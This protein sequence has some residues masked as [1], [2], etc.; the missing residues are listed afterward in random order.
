TST[1]NQVINVA[2]V[3]DAPIDGNETNI[4][5]QNATLTV[6]VG[7]NS[8]L[9]NTTDVDGST[10][11]VTSFLVAGNAT[12]F[13]VTAGTPGVANIAGVGVLTINSD[14][15][16]SFAPVANYAGAIPV[17]TYT[18]SDNAAVNPLTDSSTL[19]LTIGANNPPVDGDETNSITEDLTLTVAN[20][21]VGDLLNNATDPDNNP[22]SITSFLVAGNATPFAVT[23]GTPGVANIA[24]VGVLTINSD[25]SYS[26]APVANYAGAIPVIT[27]TVADG[28][29][30]SNT[31]TLT[32]T[33]TAV[34]DAPINTVPVA[35]TNNEDTSKAITGLSI[36]DVDAGSSSMTVTLA[37]TY[38]TLTVTGGTAAIAG[39]GTSSVTLTGT[40]A[41][42]NTTLA[43]NVIYVPTLNFNGAATLT[44]TS[45]DNGNTGSGGTLTD[46]DTVTINVSP[47]ND[48]PVNAM[49]A[50]YTTNEDTTLKLSGLSVTDVDAGTGSITVTLS[51]PSSNGTIAAT[52][53]G[54]VTV[55]GSGTTSIT[56]TGTLAN[57]NAYLASAT[58]QPT[59]TPAKDVSGTVQLTM[60]TSD[61]G[62][63]GTGNVL[64]DT[65]TVNITITPIA[66]PISDPN[67]VSVVVGAAISNTIDLSSG[68]SGVDGV[69]SFTFGNGVIMSSGSGANFN[70]SNG[71]DLGVKGGPSG[72][73]NRIDGSES[74]IFSFPSGM[75][76]MS[77]QLKNTASDTLKLTAGLEVPDLNSSG[78]ITG[79]VTCP[80][81]QGTPS[82]SNMQ[83]SLVLQYT[84]G[85][86][87]SPF[88]ATV[89]SGGAWSLSY[90]TGGKTI[91]SANV[92][93][94]V[95]GDLFNNG[96]T[97][98]T[99]FNISTDMKSFTIAPDTA[100]TYSLNDT[101]DGFQIAAISANAAITGSGYSYPVDIYAI[102]PDPSETIT[103]LKLS[104][105]PA[106]TQSLT[107]VLANGTYVEIQ[108]VGGV[109]DLSAY[110]SL[111]STSTTTSVD[112]IYLTTSTA[113]TSGF[114][115][116]MTLETVD[117]S[118]TS[119][120]II[121]GSAS[122]THTG[123]S[124]NDYINGGAGSDTINGGAGEDILVG[125][126]GADTITGGAGNDTMTGGNA[127]V[128]DSL[129]DVFVWNL[130][131]AGTV[132]SPAIDTITTFS[133]V[134]AA[135]GGDVL[136]LRDL[137]TGTATTADALD[138]YLHFEKSG[139]DTILHITSSGTYGD[140]NTVGA[141]AV[142]SAKDVQQ[143]VFTNVDLIGT[144]TTD[145]QVIQ[146]LLTNNK[147]IV[148]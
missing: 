31:S 107:V 117:G 116:T 33:I 28:V 94:L 143:I 120:T 14:G 44:M 63:T 3:N 34:N 114:S 38:G 15:S 135:S 132:G 76:S 37:M 57:I 110:T 100:K 35:Q 124:Y 18:V 133:T 108:P 61:Q 66:D 145:Q 22:L 59:Y 26:F 138:N 19:T 16:Y 111:L 65:D 91:S 127:S 82:S 85:T 97:D 43:S 80:A 21:A 54:V 13:A 96:G 77:L 69:N 113:L 49:P 11:T 64:T 84:D 122:S 10:P 9:A 144:S 39:S 130:A 137:I 50:S 79:Q 83:V 104:D 51:V 25:G 87:S 41:Q 68:G 47:V 12:P 72:G 67:S 140:N 48:V 4:V 131:D 55:S 46:V 98:A 1:A 45:S 103:S 20:G 70:L 23:A 52:G 146:N 126:T 90:N 101:N 119:V 106:D 141:D 40:V 89:S 125:G 128:D 147:L 62:N 78:T 105:L 36:S 32:L 109:Y 123:G 139:S 99:T 92:T 2:A 71:N 115:P 95:D 112:K 7:P 27:Y 88:I 93:A 142:L 136:D 5:T 129:S 56:L 102:N 134:A 58:N 6:P 81:A 75:Q 30:G 148:D 86:T 24:G 73:S 29:G 8:L 53:T 60:V 74:I 121:G 42:I 17:V 118:T